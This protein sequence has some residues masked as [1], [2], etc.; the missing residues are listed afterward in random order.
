M[1][2]SIEP[3]KSEMYEEEI[4][5]PSQELSPS[6]VYVKNL[7]E[8]L[9]DAGGFGNISKFYIY[10]RPILS[11]HM[12]HILNGIYIWIIPF[13]LSIFSDSVSHLY[14]QR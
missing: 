7:D 1:N 8:A 5:L 4:S 10:Y 14:V 9:K 13:L 3:D 11:F 12:H 6:L 2:L